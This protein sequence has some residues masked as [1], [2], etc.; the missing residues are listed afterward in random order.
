M[1][2]KEMA[3]RINTILMLS[4]YIRSMSE[5]PSERSPC[6]ISA[7]ERMNF[8]Q[9]S[10]AEQSYLLRAPAQMYHLQKNAT[11]GKAAPSF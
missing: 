3:A 10:L 7:P 4:L 6:K 1:G 11:I 5:K 8:T 9:K 2:Q